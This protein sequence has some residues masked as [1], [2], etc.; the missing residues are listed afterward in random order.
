MK[1]V[2]KL[3]SMIRSYLMI[4]HVAVDSELS[5]EFALHFAFQ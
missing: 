1:K 2:R 4:M 3:P 5:L